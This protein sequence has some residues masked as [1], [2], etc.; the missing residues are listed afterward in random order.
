ML[1]ICGFWSPDSIVTGYGPDNRGIVVRF[2]GRIRDFSLPKYSDRLCGPPA[3]YPVVTGG[4]FP[5]Q[6]EGGGVERSEC[7]AYHSL[8]CRTEIKNEWSYT[9]TYPYDFLVRLSF[10]S[11]TQC[12]NAALHRML[13]KRFSG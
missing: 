9:S 13:W 1:Y 4:I 5:R 3:S 10:T 12:S 11:T 6:E 2:Q 7:E 8:P